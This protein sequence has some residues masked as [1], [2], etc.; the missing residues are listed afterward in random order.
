[1]RNRQ[2]EKI[3]GR[4]FF[5][6]PTRNRRRKRKEDKHDCKVNIRILKRL[7]W[8]T[9]TLVA[10]FNENFYHCLQINYIDWRA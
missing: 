8:I 1:M 6:S 9:I 4:F 7:V 10:T 5:T 3:F 2:G